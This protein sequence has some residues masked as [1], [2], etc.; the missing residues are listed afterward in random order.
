M[1]KPVRVGVRNPGTTQKSPP[2][3]VYELRCLRQVRRLERRF[4]A[5][6][7]STAI[8]QAHGIRLLLGQ[9]FLRWVRELF[10]LLCFWN[11]HQICTK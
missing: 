3:G 1:H 11:L 8:A 4:P 6:E 9:A 7:P 5:I 2:L 10:A